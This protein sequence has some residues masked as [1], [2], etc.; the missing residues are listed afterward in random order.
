MRSNQEEPKGYEIVLD[1][2]APKAREVWFPPAGGRM[3]RSELE[4]SDLTGKSIN[5]A[6]NS[7]GGW[8]PGMRIYF[9]PKRLQCKII[10]R[11]SLKEHKDIDQRI[12]ELSRTDDMGRYTFG[13][14]IEDVDYSF[15]DKDLPTWMFWIKRLVDTK[16]FKVVR[17]AK[18]LPE[19]LSDVLPE[20]YQ[21]RVSEDYG[22]K[23]HNKGDQPFN[24]ITREDLLEIEAVAAEAE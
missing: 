11:M 16:K 10:D 15:R 3:L 19:K 14:Y 21:L 8:I 24:I 17:G 9:S 12:L 13:K 23:P 18:L 4:H 20:G 5:G 1:V 2:D 6:L 22:L 7:I